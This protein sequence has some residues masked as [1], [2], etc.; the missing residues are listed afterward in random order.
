MNR[1]FFL[2]GA[3]LLAAPAII[4][5]PGLLMPIKPLAAAQAEPELCITLG[6]KRYVFAEDGGWTEAPDSAV[7]WSEANSPE[8]SWSGKVSAQN[9]SEVRVVDSPNVDHWEIA[10]RRVETASEREQRDFAL[11]SSHPRG[12]ISRSA[13]T[14]KE[15]ERELLAAYRTMWADI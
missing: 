2:L 13:N 5:T 14:K 11:Y 3:G 12:L 1:R 15:P 4:R 6:G 9:F 8:F 10:T 7:H